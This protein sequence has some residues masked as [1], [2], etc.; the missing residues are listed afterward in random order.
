MTGGDLAKVVRV[1]TSGLDPR[2]AKICIQA[3]CDVDNPLLGVHGAAAIFGP[4]KGA[5]PAQVRE[6]E[7]A[8]DAFYRIVEATLQ[9][10]VRDTPGAGAAGGLGAA[11]RAFLHAALRP[12]IAIVIDAVGLAQRMASADL[13]IT[14]EGRLDAQ[15][16]HGKAPYGVARLARER[17]IPVI[18]VG[19]SLAFEAE[20][21]LAQIF[22][23]VEA[24]VTFPSTTQ[25]AL[26]DATPNLHRAG[27][28]IAQWLN[29]RLR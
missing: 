5:T 15:T 6:L 25:E 21:T 7:Q 17:G 20:A 10:S 18:A 26:V 29:L 14:G 2:L 3:A 9:L 8:L 22:D 23:A 11:L 4:Q 12:G 27:Y 19:G 1:D 28:R 16:L 24:C 13:V